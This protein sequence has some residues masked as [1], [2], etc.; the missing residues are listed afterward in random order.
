MAEAFKP[1]INHRFLLNQLE[2]CK[3]EANKL[4]TDKQIVCIRFN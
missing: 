1:I 3:L 2:M 4:K